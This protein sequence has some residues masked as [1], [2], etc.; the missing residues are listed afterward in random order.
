LRSFLEGKSIPYTV[1]NTYGLKDDKD[2]KVLL[3]LKLDVLLVMGWQRLIP[4][5][6]FE[7]FEYWSIWHA[8]FKQAFAL[9]EGKEPD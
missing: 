1:V 4:E 8:W 9:R 5:W 6:F 7:K 2:K 3:S